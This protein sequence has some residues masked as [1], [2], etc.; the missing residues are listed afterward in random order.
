MNSKLS[1][2]SL[3]ICLSLSMGFILGCQT[4]SPSTNP[5]T[6][7]VQTQNKLTYQNEQLGFSFTYPQG[8][9]VEEFT[10]DFA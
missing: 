4:N 3:G 2:L 10:I 8:Y 7:E 9:Q 6:K 5:S 1:L